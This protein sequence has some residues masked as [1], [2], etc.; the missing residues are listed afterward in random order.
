MS[1]TAMKTVNRFLGCGRGARWLFCLCLMFSLHSAFAQ[2]TAANTA[3]IEPPAGVTD[4]SGGCDAAL[5]PNCTGDNISTV[6]INI[7]SANHR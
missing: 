3:T 1:W 4:T 5:P 2:T 6:S 7:W